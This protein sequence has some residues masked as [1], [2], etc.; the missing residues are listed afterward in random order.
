MRLYGFCGERSSQA[1]S[2]S[3]WSGYCIFAACFILSIM[4]ITSRGEE[5][6]YLCVDLTGRRGSWSL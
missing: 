1:F 4:V 6:A 3:L 2:H 5:G